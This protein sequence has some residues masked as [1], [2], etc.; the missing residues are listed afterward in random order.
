MDTDSLMDPSSLSKR[1][2]AAEEPPPPP[3]WP[4]VSGV[5]TFPFYLGTLGSWMLVSLGMMVSAWLFMF[6]W[7][8]GAVLGIDAAHLFGLPTC[9]AAVLT[10]GY[11]ASCC[12]MIVEQTSYGWNAI[13][14]SPE[15]DWREWVWNYAY[16]TVLALESALVG[17]AVRVACFWESWLPVLLGTFVAYPLVLLGALA[18]SGA[19]APLAILDVLKSI[20]RLYRTWILFYLET[21]LML[22]GWILLVVMGLEETPWL[23]PLYAAPLLAAGVLIY[24][25]LIGRLA[26]QIAA[27]TSGSS[28]RRRRR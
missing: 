17:A 20:P 4:M 16:L 14:V 15:S 2:S 10:L 9:V 26:G 8:P 19:W 27:Q 22:G 3:R 11:A 7:G 6:W 28:K 1:A 12:L 25:R 13:N 5:F 23:V 21:S 24:A 18:A